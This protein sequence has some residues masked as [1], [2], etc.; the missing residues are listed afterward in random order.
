MEEKRLKTQI[1]EMKRAIEMLSGDSECFV[2]ARRVLAEE[3]GQLEAKLASLR[4]L[5]DLAK[6]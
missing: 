5:N 3:Q 6:Y 2:N 4:W 1:E